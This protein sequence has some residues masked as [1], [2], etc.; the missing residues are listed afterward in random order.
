MHI[1]EHIVPVQQ[2]G[3]AP[4]E[5]QELDHIAFMGQ[6]DIAHGIFRSIEPQRRHLFASKYVLSEV[7]IAGIRKL[8]AFLA[9]SAEQAA[10]EEKAF[11]S[12]TLDLFVAAFG[13]GHAPRELF[14]SLLLWADE[15]V[16]L[17]L[18]REALHYYDEALALG[19]NKFPELS[20]RCVMG[21]GNV[22]NLMGKYKDTESLLRSLASRPFMIAERNLLPQLLFKLGHESLLRGEVTFYK[23]LLFHALRQ[24]STEMETRRRIASQVTATYRRGYR[25]LLDGDLSPT[26]RTLYLLHRLHFFIERHRLAHRVGLTKFSRL[27]LL[28]CLYVVNYGMRRYVAVPREPAA[29][30][31][32]SARPVHAVHDMLITRA[33]G[34][35]GDLLMMTPG[36]HALKQKHPRREIH[37]AIP[38]RFFPVFTGNPDVRLLDI[39][40]VNLDPGRYRRWLNFTD[41]PAARVEARTAPKVRRSRIELFA[42]AMGIGPLGIR[43]MEKR[44]RYV[45]TPEEQAF[46]Q[47]FWRGHDLHGRVVIG[48]QL[49][50]DEVYRDY[51]HMQE[52]VE[53]LATEYRVLVFDAERIEGFSSEQVVK[54]EALPMRKAFALAAACSAIVAPD[55]AFVHLAAALD[56]P[57][58]ALYGPVDGKVRT[59][60]YPKCIYLDVR[61]KLGCLPCWRNDRIPCKL[62]GLRTSVCLADITIERILT[63]LTDILQKEQAS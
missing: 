12:E 13:R 48:V 8:R 15:L 45:V 58:V 55:S 29:G 60:H 43:R 11:I 10:Q 57:C 28:G 41:C 33:M 19:I 7:I 17:S 54:V 31:A 62:T 46:Q 23:R 4:I 34:G 32:H 14:E 61:S 26:D 42:R 22:L 52:L 21:K 40:D 38:R 49:H 9:A 63:T 30:K 39:E 5:P 53:R 2:R 44:P 51:P 35:I 36:L 3:V 1:A 6:G 37:L 50:A 56:V 27:C 59:R 47:A 20:V 18:L 16:K 25:V 24:F